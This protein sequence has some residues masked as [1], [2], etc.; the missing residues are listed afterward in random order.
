MSKTSDLLIRIEAYCA[1]RKI[2][3]ATFGL[4]TV[5]DGKLVTRLRAGRD[6]TLRNVEKIEKVLE[7]EAAPAAP[8]DATAEAAAGQ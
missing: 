3:E 2:S 8:G 5:N 7:A 4:R 6:I 1:R